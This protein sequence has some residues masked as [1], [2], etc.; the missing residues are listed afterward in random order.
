LEPEAGMGA[1]SGFLIIAGVMT[2]FGSAMSLG[3]TFLHSMSGDPWA[4]MRTGS[5]VS[6]YIGIDLGIESLFGWLGWGAVW[7]AVM[8]TPLYNVLFI[9]GIIF[10]IISLTT[11]GMSREG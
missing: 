11:R 2:L 4:P 5:F 10:I 6:N 7:Q 8:A 1:F 3:L 9:L